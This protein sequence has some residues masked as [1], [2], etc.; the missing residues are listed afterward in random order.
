MHF[1][2]TKYFKTITIKYWVMNSGN[3]GLFLWRVNGLIWLLVLIVRVPTKWKNSQRR[4]TKGFKK[5]VIH[6]FAYFFSLSLEYLYKSCQL[7]LQR[8][9]K[10]TWPSWRSEKHWWYRKAIST[11]SYAIYVNNYRTIHLEHIF[12]KKIQNSEWTI[13]YSPKTL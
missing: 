7:S 1:I 4:H 11:F 12:K 13:Q 2:T 5:R 6:S 8:K 3:Y 9:Q 10:H